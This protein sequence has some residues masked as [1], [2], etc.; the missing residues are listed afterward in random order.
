MKIN[1][2]RKMAK[3]MGINTYGVKKKDIIRAVQRAENNIAC[4]A[5]ERVESCN[6]EKCSWRD[7]CLSINNNPKS[8]PR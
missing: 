2:V 7:D 6:E 4:F 3:K 8:G 5:T 1:D